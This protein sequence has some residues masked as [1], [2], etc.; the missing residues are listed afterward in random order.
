MKAKV[1]P[2]IIGSQYLR[3]EMLLIKAVQDNSLAYPLL[4]K[5]AR[6]FDGMV[7]QAQVSCSMTQTCGPVFSFLFFFFSGSLCCLFQ[8]QNI[9]CEDFGWI[10]TTRHISTGQKWASALCPTI[11]T[12]HH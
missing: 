12:D 5:E 4:S 1:Q 3:M 8:C 2:T 11:I 10:W 6:T 7:D 9:S